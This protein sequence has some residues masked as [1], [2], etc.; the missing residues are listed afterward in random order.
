LGEAEEVFRFGFPPRYE[1]TEV[2]QPDE[3]PFHFPASAL[4]AQRPAIP[5]FLS[6]VAAVGRDLFDRHRS[7]Q[8]RP[9]HIQNGGE[10]RGV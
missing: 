10:T 3:E 6:G 2:M 4:S 1:T 5:R 7:P 9:E 8:K